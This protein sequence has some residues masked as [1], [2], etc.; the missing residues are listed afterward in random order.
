MRPHAAGPEQ[1]RGDAHA[2]ASAPRHRSPLK[3]LLLVFALS[4]PFWM[5]G[6]LTDLQL[7]PGLSVSAFMTFCP[8]VA[9]LI[10]AH[11]ENKT[12]GENYSNLRDHFS[13]ACRA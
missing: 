6:A 13:S 12:S 1:T 3:F 9:A 7:M 2:C 4:I 5:I 10:L 8:M 11:K